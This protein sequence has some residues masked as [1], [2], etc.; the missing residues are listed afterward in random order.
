[1][2]LSSVTLDYR[3]VFLDRRIYNN[4]VLQ[5]LNEIKKNVDYGRNLNALISRNQHGFLRYSRKYGIGSLKRF[6]HKAF[7]LQSQAPKAKNWT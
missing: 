3:I 5:V 1:M 7:H 6:P 2:Q 4:E